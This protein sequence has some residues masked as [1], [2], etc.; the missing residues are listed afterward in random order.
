MTNGEFMTKYVQA[1]DAIRKNW[2]KIIL[3]KNMWAQWND[4]CDYIQTDFAG[5]YSAEMID[6][7]GILYIENRDDAIRMKLTWL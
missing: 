2:A 6:D 1:T 7:T 3:S 4:I 5:S